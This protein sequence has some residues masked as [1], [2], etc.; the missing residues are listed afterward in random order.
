MKFSTNINSEHTSQAVVAAMRSRF[1]NAQLS[2]TLE[3]TDGVLHVHGVPESAENAASIISAIEET[4]FKGA[5][6]RREITNED[7]EM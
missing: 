2:A 4:G 1:P 6:I 5:W 3:A 7:S